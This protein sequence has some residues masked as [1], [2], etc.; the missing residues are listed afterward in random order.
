MGAELVYFISLL[1]PL[2]LVFL[3]PPLLYT[4][5]PVQDPI[6]HVLLHAYFTLLFGLFS[7]L[8]FLFRKN[9]TAFDPVAIVAFCTT[10]PWFLLQA[11][12]FSLQEDR[13]VWTGIYLQNVCLQSIVWVGFFFTTLIY[14]KNKLS[15]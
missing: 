12:D 9:P 14:K 5:D 2:F 6:D 7:F 3:L 13:S 1:Q 11:A 8:L 4:H 10:L 15:F